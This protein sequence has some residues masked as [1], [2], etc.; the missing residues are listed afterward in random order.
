MEVNLKKALKGRLY[1]WIGLAGLILMD[2]LVALSEADF[3]SSFV[4]RV[5]IIGVLFG[6]TYYGF[7]WA[8]VAL[9]VFL[10]LYAVS[11]L[12]VASSGKDFLLLI[13]SVQL[14]IMSALLHTSGY[15]KEFY[16]LRN[17]K[18]SGEA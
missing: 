6:L 18:R 14:L 16:L 9:S 12:L 10:I 4:S 7:S 2:L 13:Y 8:R 1:L 3:R 15:L 5:L 11:V 17:L